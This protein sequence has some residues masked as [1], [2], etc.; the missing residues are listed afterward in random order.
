MRHRQTDPFGTVGAVMLLLMMGLMRCWLQPFAAGPRV[1][2]RVQAR[3]LVLHSG[4]NARKAKAETDSS[5]PPL[6]PSPP[7]HHP[8]PRPVG[9]TLLLLLL[10]M[11]GLLKRLVQLLL[12]FTHALCRIGPEA[13]VSR[14]VIN[15]PHWTP[16]A[17]RK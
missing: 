11:K 7:P 3:V 1:Q 16:R 4:R 17:T 15:Y 12:H 14:S 5:P 2:A 8:P 9:S 13:K 10:L 6:P